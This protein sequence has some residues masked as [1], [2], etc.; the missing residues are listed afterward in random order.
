MD[1]SSTALSLLVADVS[2]E[3]IEPLIGLRRSVSLIDYMAK[4]IR[5]ITDGGM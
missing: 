5:V 2:R 3:S 4:N 1:F